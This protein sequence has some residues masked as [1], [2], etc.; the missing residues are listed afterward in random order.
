MLSKNANSLSN[1]VIWPYFM[2]AILDFGGHLEFSNWLHALFIISILCRSFMPSFMLVSP[3]ERFSHK[4]LYYWYWFRTCFLPPWNS[5][6]L[7]WFCET[8]AMK[9][10]I[11]T[12][13]WQMLDKIQKLYLVI[14]KNTKN[15][16]MIDKALTENYRQVLIN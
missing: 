7:A 8:K 9:A 3:S 10:I 6:C 2:A 16:H 14:S 1:N 15:Q 5:V 13:S 11:H 4:L 12:L